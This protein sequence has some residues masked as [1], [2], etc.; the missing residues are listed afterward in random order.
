MD[1]V[2]GIDAAE[3]D[4][5]ALSGRHARR[6]RHPHRYRCRQRAGPRPREGPAAPR[7]QARQHHRRRPRHRRRRIVFLADFGIARPLDDTS[8]LTTTN[9]TVGTVA[10]AAPEQLMGEAIDGRAD[11]YA[12]GGHRLS[13]ADRR[14]AVPAL[15]PGRRHQP[16]PQ[17][18]ASGY[19]GHPS[20]HRRLGFRARSSTG[21]RP[22][23]ALRPLR[24]LRTRTARTCD[25][26]VRAVVSGRD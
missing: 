1:Y 9:M 17:R 10:Y 21:E 5:D 13:L 15:Q 8:G 24:G 26:G 25:D 4:R 22:R 2:D 18:T 16:P 14:A 12:L 20:R 11:Q 7:R 6:A 3:L 23:E 19:R